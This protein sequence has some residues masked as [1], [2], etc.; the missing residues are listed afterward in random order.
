MGFFSKVGVGAVLLMIAG[1]VLGIRPDHLGAILLMIAI[2]LTIAA[3]ISVPV[4]RARAKARNSAYLEELQ[5]HGFH[6]TRTIKAGVV[7]VHFDFERRV[8]T[9]TG[10]NIYS[11][12]RFYH[13]RG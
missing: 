13:I 4:R 2:P 8:C 11:G 12:L 9:F 5:A 7:E 6:P 3:I 1:I 10:D